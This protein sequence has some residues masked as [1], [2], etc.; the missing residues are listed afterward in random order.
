MRGA[1]QKAKSL[2]LRA[3]MSLSRLWRTQGKTTEVRQL[4]AEVYAWFA[5]GFDPADLKP[6]KALIEELS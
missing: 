6:A 2:E 4:L 1:G 3:A 5:E